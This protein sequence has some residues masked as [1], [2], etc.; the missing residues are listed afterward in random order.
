MISSADGAVKHAEENETADRPH[1]FE[2]T[3]FDFFCL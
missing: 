2:D 3:C 1:H